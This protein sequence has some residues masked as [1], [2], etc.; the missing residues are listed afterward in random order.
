MKSRTLFVGIATGM[1]LMFAQAVFAAVDL[2]QLIMSAA[3]EASK[4]DLIKSKLGSM[5][6]SRDDSVRWLD[7]VLS[8]EY[9]YPKLSDEP[10]DALRALYS[11]AAWLLRNGHPIAGGALVTIARNRKDFA[12]SDAG[13][14]MVHFVDAMLQPAEEDDYELMEYQKKSATVVK[15]LGRLPKDKSGIR[16]AAM[17]M[18]IGEIYQ[19]D[20]AVNAGESALAGLTATPDDWAIIKA[21]RKAANSHE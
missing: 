10:S 14:G 12:G 2:H 11:D 4:S 19:D 15:Q 5:P 13:K 9:G 8:L 6:I 20:I 1:V 7:D 3:H 17:V 16:M 18:L 21:A